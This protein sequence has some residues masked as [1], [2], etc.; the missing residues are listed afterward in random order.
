[1][2]THANYRFRHVVGF[3]VGELD[4]RSMPDL[5]EQ[6]GKTSF[7]KHLR[8]VK[9]RKDRV[10]FEALLRAK[11]GHNVPAL[12]SLNGLHDQQERFNGAY[13]A[14]TDITELRQATNV[15]GEVR[16]ELAKAARHTAP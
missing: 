2:I 14:I 11:D 4:G 12:L 7:S 15:L 9:E 5:L 8:L 13:V 1:M 6:A 3:T 16:K 10:E